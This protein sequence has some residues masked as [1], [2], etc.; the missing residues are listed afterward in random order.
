MTRVSRG[1]RK[2]H[3]LLSAVL[4]GAFGIAVLMF[5]IPSANAANIVQLQSP[6][7][8]RARG[9][10]VE[11][12]VLVVC[13]LRR[14]GTVGQASSPGRATLTVDLVERV[15]GGNATGSGKAASRDGDFRCDNNS[16]LVHLFVPASAAGKAF[17][18]GT[19]FGQTTLKVCA[20]RCKSVTDVR[21][22]K[23]K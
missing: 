10:A 16:H 22:I 3:G 23:L 21:E 5:F 4:V 14:P 6:A 17:A 12:T 11:V 1:G 19:A 15:G 2:Q 20:P 8:L 7:F 18:K 9:A 13:K